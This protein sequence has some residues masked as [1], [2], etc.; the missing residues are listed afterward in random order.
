MKIKLNFAAIRSFNYKLTTRLFTLGVLSTMMALNAMAESHVTMYPVPDEVASSHYRVSVDGQ[1]SAVLH[2]ASSYYLLNFDTDG[3]VTI[4]VTADD[5]HFW[6]QGVEIQPM[7]LGI[8]PHRDGA[9]ITFQLAGAEKV[10]IARPRDR[11][12]DADL[13][14]LF[15]NPP[16][17]SGITATTPGVR[18]FGPGVHNENIDA[19]SGDKIYLDGGAV[20]F[21][22]LNI[23]QVENVKVFGRGTIIYDGPQNP[24]SDEGWMHKPNWH[25]L[26]MDNAKN[27][28]I[29]GITC[30]TR[31]RSWQIQMKD[32]HQILYDNIKVI[33]GN[34]NNANQDGMDW[35]GGGDTIVRN[36]FFRASDDDF[37]LQ[38]NWDGYDLAKMRIPGH[39]V[40][41]I[42]IE[43]TMVST[44][45]SNT[46]RVA[47]PEKTFNSTSLHMHD[48]DVLNMGPGGCKVPFAFFELWADPTGKGSHSDYSFSDI[49]LDEWYS[50]L[51]IRQ[52]LPQVRNFTFSDIWA[53]DGPGMV[54]SVLK[55]DVSGIT[56][57][58]ATAQ[59]VDGAVVRAEA[60]AAPPTI[61]PSE[62]NADF[63]YSKG[64]LKPGKKIKF[65]ATE[66]TAPDKH[67]EWLFGDGSK[68]LGHN[69][70][71][72]FTDADGTLLDGSGRFRVLLHVT[73]LQGHQAWSN[74]SVVVAQHVLPQFQKQ[75]SNTSQLNAS[76]SKTVT[77]AVNV[78]ADGGY[79]FTFLTS[80]QGSMQLD[81]LSPIPTPKPQPQVCGLLGN[82]VQSVVQS[83]VL[84]RGPHALT[85]VR[86]DDLEYAETPSGAPITDPIVLWEGPGISRTIVTVH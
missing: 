77:L 34:P 80:T 63:T 33:G 84:K 79:T 13:L 31:S 62:L 2:A 18:Y 67:Y 11:F 24:H 51:Q 10:M 71:H 26:V 16:D 21:G 29:D 78:L 66:P 60:G 19:H 52:P 1:S 55:G 25:V 65:K 57:Q 14:F 40:N 59:G 17:T 53:M 45:I 8:R 38:G 9:T 27:I 6:D 81:D 20:I 68:A 74:Q 58:D 23:W 15:A 30:I 49:R 22:S 69:V 56:L 61:L 36:S 42:T 47:W 75:E 35:L 46:V 44:S 54:P 70:S 64:I 32:S 37:A 73:D 39:D 5:P 4:S 50:L 86:N 76:G 12:S 3:P 85:I 43:H 7:R 72:R 82:S 41:N 48:I 28:E 83:A